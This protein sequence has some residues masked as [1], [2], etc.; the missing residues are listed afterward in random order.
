MHNEKTPSQIIIV[1]G[2]PRSGTSLMMQILQASGVPVFQDEKRKPDSHNPKGYYESEKVKN[3]ANENSWLYALKG[4]SVKIVS[5]LLFHLPQDLPCKIIFMQRNLDEVI[6]SQN[7]MM[8]EEH[9]SERGVELKKYYLKH[10]SQVEN[11]LRKSNREYI[12]ISF[13]NLI[14]NPVQ[15]V[16][17]LYHFLRIPLSPEKVSAVVTP[18]LYRTK[19]KG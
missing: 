11:W 17:K 19:K 10:L 3:L 15:A 6:S 4:K 7:K 16:E 18:T 2:L 14:S 12:F 9:T 8:G 13:N 1:S 5:P